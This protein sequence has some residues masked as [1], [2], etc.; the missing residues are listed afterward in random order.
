MTSTLTFLAALK[1]FLKSPSDFLSSSMNM[2]TTARPSSL[3][4]MS[5]SSVYLVLKW[6]RW[7]SPANSL[8][9][10]VCSEPLLLSLPQWK[11]NWR[12][13]YSWSPRGPPLRI[14]ETCR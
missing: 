3:P 14:L 11:W 12:R 6:T 9:S 2:P 8:P 10:R 7:S 4:R 13:A 5:S 1:N